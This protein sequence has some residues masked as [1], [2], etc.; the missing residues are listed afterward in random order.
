MNAFRDFVLRPGRPCRIMADE[1]T[2][3]GRPPH[4]RDF[5]TSDEPATPADHRVGVRDDDTLSAPG[6][7]RDNMGDAQS[8]E[9]KD[10]DYPYAAFISYRHAEL[11]RRWAKW[12]HKTLETYRVPRSLVRSRGLPPRIGRVFRDEEELPVSS[13]LSGEID[14]ALIASKFLI[15]IC[16]RQ[17]PSSKWVNRE[18]ERFRELGRGDRILAVLIDGEPHE[19]FP[20]ALTEIRRATTGA[21]PITPGQSASAQSAAPDSVGAHDPSFEAVEPLAA[22]VRP[23][24]HESPGHLVR[25]ARMRMIACVLGVKFDDLRNRELHRRNRRL[26]A[27]GSVAA[28]L[29]VLMSFLTVFAFVQRRNAVVER[30]NA[31]AVLD[32]LTDEVLT[33]ASPD[34]LGDPAA[35]E[36][37]VR[38]AIL[39]ATHASA[40]RFAADKPLVDAAIRSTLAS[41]LDAIGHTR[42]ALEQAKIALDARDRL[43]GPDHPDRLAS[44]A[45][46]ASILRS[47]G[48]PTEAEPL[49]KEA[50]DRRRKVRGPA[51]PETIQ[52]IQIYAT[53]LRALGRPN[54][55]LPLFQEARDLATGALGGNHKDALLAQA[56]YAS[57]LRSVG[58]AAEAEAPAKDVY[59]RRLKLLGP[60]HPDTMQSADNV[61]RILDTLGRPRE[62]DKYSRDVLDR[63][64]RV[65]GPD[66]AN[67]ISSLVLR[68]KIMESMGQYADADGMFREAIERATRKLGAG[69]PRTIGAAVG[70]ASVLLALGQ[71]AEAEKV[72]R[73]AYDRAI[74][75]MA[76]GQFGRLN[77]A[78]TFA[79]ALTAAGKAVQAESIAKEALER[80]RELLGPDQPDTLATQAVYATAVA[81]RSPSQA[82]PLIADVQARRTKA[83]GPDHPQTLQAMSDHARVLAALGK[84]TQ[85]EPIAE[86]VLER[87]RKVLGDEHPDTIRSLNDYAAILKTLGRTDEAT[88]LTAEAVKLATEPRQ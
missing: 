77:A 76:Q 26:V 9:R 10:D 5:D 2:P 46:Y 69:N 31:K 29:L 13:S 23:I 50:L 60:D 44:L 18:V 70:H 1:P 71:T 12:L 21:N 42:L 35:A 7:E 65:L 78:T 4:P 15:V 85:A 17:T 55:A 48:R 28:S 54:E 52:S 24:R 30:D 8:A 58:R 83:L 27:L 33:G 68:G 49:A 75:T 37:V 59:E 53:I 87:R 14:K 80:R 51:H 47:A 16:S 38:A 67:T 36:A 43:L 20:K 86:T 34:R 39:P 73:D 45:T 22:D 56:N 79:G 66:H 82:E 61:A 84:T 63:R 57:A 62:A 88:R 25:M 3:V 64:W 72:A 19:S 40:Q 74:E 32:F 11:D 41:T 81:A 6:A